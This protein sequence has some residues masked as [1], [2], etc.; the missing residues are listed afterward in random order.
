MEHYILVGHDVVP[1]KDIIVWANYYSSP[2]HRN[3][4]ETI[5]GNIRVSTIFLG[6]NVGDEA[7][8]FFET[9]IF[10]GKHDQYQVRYATFDQ[11]VYGHIKVCTLAFNP[12]YKYILSWLFNIKW[13]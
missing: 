6:V 7:P 13:K 12:I 1:C 3:I 10:G 11:A 9:M 4:A 5:R 8:L 2:E